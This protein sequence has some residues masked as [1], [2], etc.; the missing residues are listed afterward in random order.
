[1]GELTRNL[2]QEFRVELIDIKAHCCC[3][4]SG[5]T[6]DAIS[7]IIR[8]HRIDPSEIEEIDLYV[9]PAVYRLTGKITRPHDITSAQFGGR[10][11]VALR[12]I[13]G[14]NS[15]RDYT[16]ANLINPEVL[17]LEA[18]TNIV[19]DQGLDKNPGADHPARALI[20]TAGGQAYEATV[21]APRGSVLNPM[22][23]E[24]VHGK[25]RSF[26]SELLPVERTEAI[27]EIVSGM[28]N[29]RDLGELGR[30][31]TEKEG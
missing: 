13:K 4:T 15:F 6:I 31:L 3:G 21:L 1:M 24:E 7:Q 14:E 29:V 9:S 10:F 25:F 5:S 28:E 26:S 30:L 22:P 11:G 17:S 23:R 18:R 20:R 16:E 2:G 27:I 19:V 12:L 8:E